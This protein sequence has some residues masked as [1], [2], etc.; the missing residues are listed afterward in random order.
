M[1]PILL[2]FVFV[3]V[4]VEFPLYVAC[5]MKAGSNAQCRPL[6]VSVLKVYNEP[7]EPSARGSVAPLM[8]P[9]DAIETIPAWPII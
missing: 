5:K 6:S 4:P 9:S 8:T 1:A 3:L 7:H 2:D